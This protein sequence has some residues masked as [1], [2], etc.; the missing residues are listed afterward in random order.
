MVVLEMLLSIHMALLS[1][2]IKIMEEAAFSSSDNVKLIVHSQLIVVHNNYLCLIVY[3]EHISISVNVYN[4]FVLLQKTYQSAFF[5]IDN[6]RDI[7]NIFKNLNFSD[8]GR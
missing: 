1:R 5:I 6:S 7:N 3:H 2:I 4:T 8:D